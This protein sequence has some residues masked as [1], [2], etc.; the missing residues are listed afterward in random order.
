MLLRSKQVSEPIA[1]RVNVWSEVFTP[2][3]ADEVRTRTGVIANDL[4]Y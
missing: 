1:A 4:G 2:A 3:M